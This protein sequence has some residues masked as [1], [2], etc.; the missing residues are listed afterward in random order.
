MQEPEQMSAEIG[1]P[2][3]LETKCIETFSSPFRY[4]CNLVYELPL[5]TEKASDCLSVYKYIDLYMYIKF[6]NYS[7][8]MI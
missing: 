6:T 2:I 1:N 5:F 8:L 7:V 4:V 3:Y